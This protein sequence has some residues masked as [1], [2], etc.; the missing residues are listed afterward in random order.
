M[1][2]AAT[3]PPNAGANKGISARVSLSSISIPKK[4]L[5]AYVPAGTAMTEMNLTSGFPFF[6]PRIKKQYPSREQGLCS[7]GYSPVFRL[8]LPRSCVRLLLLLL[9]SCRS[10]SFSASSKLLFFLVRTLGERIRFQ[11]DVCLYHLPPQNALH[12]VLFA[13]PVPFGVPFFAFGFPYALPFRLVA[14]LA[15][16]RAPDLFLPNSILARFI[17]LRRCPALLANIFRAA[18]DF[19]TIDKVPRQQY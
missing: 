6:V 4:Y 2:V 1:N 7:A 10:R 8:W 3:S 18:D 11:P 17:R 9:S 14:P 16:F 19:G 13:Q 5:I 15:P 12:P